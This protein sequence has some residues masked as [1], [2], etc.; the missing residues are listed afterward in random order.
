MGSS[1]S[2][3]RGPP[4]I[5]DHI[6]ETPAEPEESS[7]DSSDSIFILDNRED[8]PADLAGGVVVSWIHWLPRRVVRYPSSP[9]PRR[10]QLIAPRVS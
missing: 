4:S 10:V 6:S 5:F 3:L 1:A 9:A 2:I 8:I 7:V